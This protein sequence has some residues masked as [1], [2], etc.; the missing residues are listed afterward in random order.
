[1]NL[2]Y[3]DHFTTVNNNPYAPLFVSVDDDDDIFE[4]LPVAV[5]TATQSAPTPLVQPPSI[6]GG[7]TDTTN[8]QL[9]MPDLIEDNEGEINEEEQYQEHLIA[10]PNPRLTREMKRISGF[11][12]PTA[13]KM[14]ETQHKTQSD[15]K[16]QHKTRLDDKTQDEKH[17][18]L[19]ET[20]QHQETQLDMDEIQE[21]SPLTIPLFED[22][23]LNKEDDEEDFQDDLSDD[24]QQNQIQHRALMMVQ[25]SPINPTYKAYNMFQ[26]NKDKVSNPFGVHMSQLKDILTVPTSYEDAYYHQ[27]SWCRGLWRDAINLELLKMKQ[28]K[29]WHTVNK[30]NIPKNRRCIKNK[31]V[32][33]INVLG[34]SEQD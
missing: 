26:N 5:I 31:W 1:M 10:S 28:L 27:N 8:S 20:Q 3:D 32:F 14:Y 30:A 29:V 25:Y 16:T 13:T 15:N 19:D 17:K 4:E 9:E 12:N 7:N 33:D 18:T 6:S 2:M 11:F 22:E 23:I 24:I 21:F 34:Y